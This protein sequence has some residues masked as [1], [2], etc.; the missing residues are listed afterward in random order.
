MG[1][2]NEKRADEGN[3]LRVQVDGL[4]DAVALDGK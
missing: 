1:R 2:L 3:I 4:G